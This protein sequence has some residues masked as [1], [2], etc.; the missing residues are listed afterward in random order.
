M[1]ELRVDYLATHV[2]SAIAQFPARLG[3]MRTILTVRREVDGGRYAGSEAQRRGLILDILRAS[4]GGTAFTHV[5]LEADIRGVPGEEEICAAAARVRTT[6]IRSV[7]AF[8]YSA[9]KTAAL[10]EQVTVAADEIGK[11][12]VAV[13][14]LQE[15]CTIVEQLQAFRSQQKN[16][17]RGVIVIAMG[18]YG[19][20]LR[21][22]SNT[23]NLYCNLLQCA[24]T[25]C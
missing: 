21:I 8:S 4:H 11:V 12:A 6:V 10:L 17:E 16:R 1:C 3:G 19:R 23:L 18:E 24:G 5:D 15:V 2:P 7:H 25:W 14:S 9:D 20:V 22:I 13:D